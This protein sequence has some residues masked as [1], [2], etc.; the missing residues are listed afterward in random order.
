MARLKTSGKPEPEPEPED[1][2]IEGENE[3]FFDSGAEDRLMIGALLETIAVR[4]RAEPSPRVQFA[5]DM[6]TIAA[7]ERAIRIMRSDLPEE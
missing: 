1:D 6:L 5:L 7:C 4:H 2:E 3:P